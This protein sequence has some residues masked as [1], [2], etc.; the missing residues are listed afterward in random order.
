MEDKGRKKRVKRA[1]KSG[2]KWFVPILPV[3]LL[4]LAAAVFVGVLVKKIGMEND[5]DKAR[6]TLLENNLQAA[7]GVALQALELIRQEASIRNQDARS[8]QEAWQQ[9]WPEETIITEENK[10]GFA[11]IERCEISEEDAG[12]VVVSGT[13]KGIPESDDRRL[14][15]FSF[16]V[17]QDTM[18][19]GQE[20]ITSIRKSDDRFS[21]TVN[22]NYKQ[23]GSRLF[24]KFAMGIKQN[25][26]YVLLSNQSYIT[27]PER[28][29]QYQYA[30]PKAASIKGLLVDP[31]KLDSGE[32][33]DLGVKQAAYNIMLGRLVGQTSSANYPT[34]YYNYA[35][36]T[37]AFD[38]QVVAEYDIV[39]SKLTSMG[40]QITAIILNDWNSSHLDLIHPNARSA[41]KCQYYM[42]N[43][44][45]QAGV[46]YLGA[47]ATFLAERYS[48][49][50]HGQ[51]VNWVIANEINARAEWNY[52]P[53]VD[54]QTYSRVYA[55]GFRVFYNAI[56]SVN[57]NARIYMPIDQTWNRNL[58]SGA[59]DGRDVLDYFNAYIKEY[60]NIDWDLSQHPYP[61]PLTHAAFWNMPSNYRRMNLITYTADSPM[62][63][64]QNINVVT[65][66]LQ[67]EEFLNPEGESRSVTLSEVGFTSTSG[68]GVQAAAFAYAYYIAEA[69]SHIDALLL[70][71]Q[72]DAEAE[73]AQGLA[74]GINHINGTHKQ[75]YQVFK[76]IDT[77]RSQEVTEFAKGIIGIS[78][79]S[80]VIRHY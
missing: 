16:A 18:N 32:L 19:E 17:Y 40:I 54:V 62:V 39:F 63:S 50:G 5:V 11:T 20:P 78:S 59:Y 73:L 79:W 57:A 53:A 58:K 31:H 43:A 22:L 29:A 10:E 60:G 65:D 4:L 56:K 45:D 44:A 13:M 15:L 72:T 34:I 26:K 1:K 36:K 49:T 41:G 77:G 37:Y 71:R 24:D 42:F 70:N 80:E 66:Y 23:A 35:G 61:V 30:Y 69:N 75:I 52:Y 46:D 38:G 67:R 9:M 8:L 51:V 47:A 14:Y 48:G 25:G 12:K 68:E 2:K 74:L 55:D 6:R 7:E 33:Q 21:F 76:Y 64:I 27:N 3:V 28:R